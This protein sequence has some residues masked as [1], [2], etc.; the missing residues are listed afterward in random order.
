MRG[1]AF[2][3]RGCRNAVA[4]T[5]A[6]RA[7][8]DRL[9]NH[10]FLT[11]ASLSKLKSEQGKIDVTAELGNAEEAEDVFTCSLTYTRVESPAMAFQAMELWVGGGG[12]LADLSLEPGCWHPRSSRRWQPSFGR[13][14]PV[15]IY[16]CRSLLYVVVGIDGLR[17]PEP[18]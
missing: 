7:R 13:G 2:L 3:R 17:S 5:R 18:P 15:S 16:C 6:V 9:C 4:F 10:A 8:V 12:L 11:A 1:K 14:V